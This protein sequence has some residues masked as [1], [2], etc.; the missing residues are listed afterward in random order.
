MQ[1]HRIHTKQ[2]CLINKVYKIYFCDMRGEPKN[3][4][5]VFT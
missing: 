3:K 1:Y 4:H 5:Y 2:R